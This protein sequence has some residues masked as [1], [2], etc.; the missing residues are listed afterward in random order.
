MKNDVIPATLY[1]GGTGAAGAARLRRQRENTD[2]NE[3]VVRD[4]TLSGELKHPKNPQA[5][6]YTCMVWSG[7]FL[8]SVT[9]VDDL[10]LN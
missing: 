7:L 5:S 2:L 3:A 4:H 8:H 1:Q 6:Q 10:F 9:S